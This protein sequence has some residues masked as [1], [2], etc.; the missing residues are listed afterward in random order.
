MFVI[1]DGVFEN[2]D[3][4]FGYFRR[5]EKVRLPSSLKRIG[6]CAFSQ[7]EALT[8]ISLPDG[9]ESLGS[10]VFRDTPGVRE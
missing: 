6:A 2:P 3:G 10:T 1:E 7:C 9:A 8:E 4:A 5:L